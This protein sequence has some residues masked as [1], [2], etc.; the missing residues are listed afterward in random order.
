MCKIRLHLG[1]YWLQILLKTFCWCNSIIISWHM[2]F[3]ACFQ[4]LKW[5]NWPLRMMANILIQRFFVKLGLFSYFL[6]SQKKKMT[7]ALFSITMIIFFTS[8]NI[9]DEFETGWT[10]RFG[11]K[12]KQ[13]KKIKFIGWLLGII[14]YKWLLLKI[15]LLNIKFHYPNNEHWDLLMDKPLTLFFSVYEFVC[16]VL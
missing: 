1:R 5:V 9:W 6:I 4:F 14:L 13:E 2:L 15:F 16:S 8:R 3:L 11:Q 10:L 12:S 7:Y